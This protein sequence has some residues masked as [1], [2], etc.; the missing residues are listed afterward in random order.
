MNRRIRIGVGD[1]IVTARDFINAWKHAAAGKKARVEHR[2]YFEDIETLMKALTPARWLLLKTSRSCGPLSVR[3]LARQ[4]G[5][6]YKNVHGDVSR[7]EQ[8]GLIRR[9][10][11]KRVEVPWDVIEA[12]LKLAA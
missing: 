8:L 10:P 4:L 12:Q 6:D 3:S 9:T 1:S 2:L 7:L 11:D 5:R